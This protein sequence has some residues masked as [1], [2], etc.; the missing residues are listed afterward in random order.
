VTAVPAAKPIPAARRGVN[1]SAVLPYLAL[2]A[3]TIL[4]YLP[5]ITGGMLWDDDAHITKPALQSLHG[6]WRIWFDLNATQQ[7]YPLLHSAFWFEHRLWGD[8]TAGYHLVNILLHGAS[9][10]LV[11]LIARRLALPGAWL[12]G[13]V[14]ALHPVCVEGVAWISEQKSTLSGVLCLGAALVYLKFDES[15]RWLDYLVALGLFIAALAA[16]TVTATLPGALLVILWWRRGAPGWKMTRWKE[17]AMPLAPWFAISAAAGALTA[18]VEREYIG[19]HG[20]VFDLSFADR[21]LIA[22]RAM[23]FYAAKLLWPE[24]LSFI[25]PHW[26]IDTGVWWQWL[27]PAGA[28]LVA[29]GLVWFARRNRGPLTALLLFAGML[30][31]AL[32]FLNVYPFRYS[33]VADHFQYLA[34]LGLIVPLCALLASVTRRATKSVLSVL[35]L[36]GVPLV[37]AALTFQQTRQ[38][39]DAETLYRETL[40][41]NPECWMAHNNLGGLYAKL[42]D[43][44]PDA[45]AEYEA[46]LRIE[47]NIVEAET[48]LGNTLRDVPGREAEALAHLEKALS[49]DPN[50]ALAHYNLGVA[51][52][53]IPGRAADAVREYEATIRAGSDTPVVRVNLGSA[54]MLL[55]GRGAEAMAQFEEALRLDPDSAEAENNIALALARDPDQLAESVPH[56]EKALKI[57]PDFPEAHSNFGNALERMGRVEDA[58]REQREAIRLRPDYALAHVNLAGTLS[59]TPGGGVEALAEYQTA[60]RLNPNLAETHFRLAALLSDAPGRQAEAIAEYREAVRLRPDYVEAHGNL[61]LLL[62]ATPGRMPD[63]LAEYETALRIDPAAAE[64]QYDLAEALVRLGRRAEAIAHLEAALSARPDAEPVRELLARLKAGQ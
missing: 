58:I 16:K 43:R 6:L 32:G 1:L 26:K 64:V 54:L 23:W 52:A 13:Y 37:L 49:I 18:Y 50:F 63:A 4:A 48:S 38:Y 55:P 56:F 25:Y 10:C 46:A 45:I 5:A 42:P 51:L 12:A 22:G 20:A 40:A 27:F 19:A 34:S 47:P 61:G 21:F 11:V 15:R 53:A 33:F 36:V 8:A 35:P 30:F 44:V 39:R 29:A 24:N 57:R 31:P 60:L 14:F 41:R 59:R 2:I 62:A 17:D 28:L 9:A 7:Y 3:V